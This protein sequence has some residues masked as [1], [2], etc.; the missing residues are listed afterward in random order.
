MRNAAF[1]AACIGFGTAA[2]FSAPQP[3]AASFIQYNSRAA[4]DALGNYTGVDWGVFGPAGT[5]ISTPDY[6]TVGG[7]TIGVAS[8]QGVLA[9]VDEGNGYVGDFAPGDHLLTD[10]GSESDS[11]I[12]SFGTP[13][14]GFGTQVDAH[15]ISGPYTGEIDV[16]GAANQLL[17]TADFSGDRTGAEDNSAPFVGVLSSVPDISYVSFLINQTQPGPP[18]QS[19]AVVINRLDVLTAVPEPMSVALLFPALAVVIVMRRRGSGGA[20][21]A[22]PLSGRD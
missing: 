7:L 8:S 12:V 11:F 14:R 6:R 9:R 10:A 4:F 16:F 3:A 2:L 15:Y 17:Y 1:L 19:G 5:T 18:P 21:S 20:T 13:V 22:A